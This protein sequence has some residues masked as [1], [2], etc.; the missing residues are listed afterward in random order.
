MSLSLSVLAGAGW[1]FFDNNGNPLNGGLVYTYQSGTTTPV[2]TYTTSSGLVSNMNP[3]VLD[4]AGR[5]PNEIWITGGVLCTFVLKTSA[6]V[7]I[8]TYDEISGVNDISLI[9][10]DLANTSDNTKG[11]ALVGFKQSNASGFLTNAVARTVNQKLQEIISI[12]DFGAVGDG[13]TDNTAAIQAALDLGA[14]YAIG[15]P[16]G[17]F[18]TT[19][20]TCGPDITIRGLGQTISKLKL[21]NGTSGAILSSSNAANLI[22][23]DL[24]FDGNKNNCP[25]GTHAVHIYGAESGGHGFLID[26]CGFYSCK[27][28]GIYQTGT[29]TKVRIADCTI[30]SNDLDGVSINADGLVTGNRCTYNGRFGVLATGNYIQIIGNI[31]NSNGQIVT[32][33]A[34]I[35]VVGGDYAI[36]EGNTCISNGTGTYFTHGL[37]FNGVSNGIMQ[38]NFCQLNNG[39]GLD[40]YNSQYTTCSGNQSLNNKMRGIENDSDSKYSTITGNVVIGN[41]DVGISIYNTI[42]SIVANNVAIG[43]GT[44]GTSVNP[45]TGVVSSP[46]GIALWGAGNYG[47]YSSVVGNNISQNIGS[48]ANGVGLWVDP[49]CVNVSLIDNDFAGNTTD[50]SAIVG[51]FKVVRDNQGIVTAQSGTVAL[52]AGATSVSVTFSPAFKFAPSQSGVNLTLYNTPFTN[53][54]V[55]AVTAISTTGFTIS[56]YAAPGGSGVTIGWSVSLFP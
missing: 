16:E 36:A 51:N 56:T 53:I 7:T 17:V 48:G 43:N 9:L 13:V 41:Y 33:G 23:K 25:S 37:Q 5:T 24:G 21:K 49:S 40:M 29:Y 39:S 35:G 46:Y 54:G 42:G 12:S 6:G 2:T 47:N 19:N 26:S 45:L 10:A 4:S 52:G 22:I 34:G 27:S 8:G 28:N 31:C 44:L 55:M 14:G 38:G 15:V 18:V 30:E 50:L 3:I 11:D 32:S 1:Q 20:L